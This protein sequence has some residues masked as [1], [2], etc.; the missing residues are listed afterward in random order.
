MGGRVVTSAIEVASK[1]LFYVLRWPRWLKNMLKIF[2]EK[3]MTLVPAGF[4]CSY[5]TNADAARPGRLHKLLSV[6]RFT[7]H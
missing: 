5:T 4:S 7:I 2:E 6:L 3:V 1:S